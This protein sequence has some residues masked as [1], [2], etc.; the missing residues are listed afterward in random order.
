[1]TEPERTDVYVRLA[2]IPPA[3]GVDVVPFV[4]NGSAWTNA[5]EI[6]L[7]PG[8]VLDFGNGL[9]ARAL[10]ADFPGFKPMG[11]TLVDGSGDE[12]EA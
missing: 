7:G 2:D 9:V 6:R 11:I 5:E 1:M 12:D 10:P 8:R 4:R 3:D